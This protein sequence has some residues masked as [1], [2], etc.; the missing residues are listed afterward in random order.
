MTV[1]QWERNRLPTPSRTRLPNPQMGAIEAQAQ[2]RP[3]PMVTPRKSRQNSTMTGYRASRLPHRTAST[4]QRQIARSLNHMDLSSDHLMLALIMDPTARRQLER[5]GDIIELR[6]TATQRV[7]RNYT[8]SS[9]DPGSPK[10]SSDLGDIA[11]K[12]R[13]AAAEREQLVSISDLINAFPKIGDRLT[14]A[15]GEG[16]P[17]TPLFKQSRTGSVLASPTL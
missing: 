3:R 6:E 17:P 16:A 5:V 12:A 13:D 11:K 15:S 9:A 2:P 10:P 14:Y 8:K 4:G 1:G 7:G